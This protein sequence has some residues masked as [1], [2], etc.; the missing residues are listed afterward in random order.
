MKSKQLVILLF[1][2]IASFNACS[3]GPSSTQKEPW[4]Q[5][6]LLAP[7]DLAKTINNP[8]APQPI[9]FCIGPQAVIPGSIDIGPT[10]DK[11]NLE[12]LKAQLEKTPKDASI[13]IYCGCCPYSRC[14]NVRPAFNMLNTMQFKNHMLLDLPQNI[15]VDWIDK[16][17]PVVD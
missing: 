1:V 4:T 8:G 9:I 3:Q 7:A 17:Y 12:K 5:A 6:Q 11:A 10:V 2:M 14:P 15:K 16:G 13:V